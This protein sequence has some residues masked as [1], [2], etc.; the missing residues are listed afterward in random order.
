MWSIQVLS[1]Q[2]S[3]MVGVAEVSMQWVEIKAG[4]SCC[5]RLSTSLELICTDINSCAVLQIWVKPSTMPSSCFLF[6]PVGFFFV[7]ML[8]ISVLVYFFHFSYKFHLC[9][10]MTHPVLPKSKFWFKNPD[11]QPLSS[12][13]SA[14]VGFWVYLVSSVPNIFLYYF[15][16]NSLKYYSLPAAFPIPQTSPREN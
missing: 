12:I 9:V 14:H 8:F 6:K 1:C 13:Q 16:F 10:Y 4:H 7:F 11:I 2:C 3:K 15:L 5:V